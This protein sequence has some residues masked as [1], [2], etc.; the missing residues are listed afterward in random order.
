MSGLKR[1]QMTV[2]LWCTVLYF[3][4]ISN[5]LFIGLTK[6]EDEKSF[7]CV[8]YNECQITQS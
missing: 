5:V 8:D 4:A 7:E 1:L 6:L 2:Y 3:Y